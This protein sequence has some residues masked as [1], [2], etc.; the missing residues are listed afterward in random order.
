MSWQP[1]P[2]L[3]E[4]VTELEHRLQVLADFMLVDLDA[5]TILTSSLFANGIAIDWDSEQLAE[6]V[7][8]LRPYVERGEPMPPADDA[9][10]KTVRRWMLLEWARQHQ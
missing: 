5:L 9:R 2:T 8:E 6:D 7:A 3:T 1:E 10:G 4:R